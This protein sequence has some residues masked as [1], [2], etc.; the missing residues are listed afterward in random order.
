[1]VFLESDWTRQ[2]FSRRRWRGRRGGAGGGGTVRAMV[3]Y[4]ET[5]EL[6]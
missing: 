4:R 5:G 2:L 1:M 6:E 3:N